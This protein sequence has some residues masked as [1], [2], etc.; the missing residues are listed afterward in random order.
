MDRELVYLLKHCATFKH[1]DKN[2]QSVF[3]QLRPVQY[4][5]NAWSNLSKDIAGPFE[6]APN[7]RRIAITLVD[8]YSKW[9]S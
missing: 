7:K 6:R 9:P 3:V 1:N 2:V 4:S 8:Y 5:S